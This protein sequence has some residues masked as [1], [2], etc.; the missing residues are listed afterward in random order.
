MVKCFIFMTKTTG[1]SGME[2]TMSKLYDWSEYLQSEFG[3]EVRFADFESEDWS[4]VLYYHEG[5]NPQGPMGM[6]FPG[7]SLTIIRYELWGKLRG[8]K[9]LVHEFGHHL[10]YLGKLGYKDNQFVKDFWKEVPKSWLLQ[11]APYKRQEE[12]VVD[13]LAR[14]AAKE[15]ENE[16]LYED[17]LGGYDNAFKDF[18]ISL[19]ASPPPF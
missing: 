17:L 2:L 19:G 8:F 13:C 1:T 3:L 12:M 4:K 6:Y 5:E 18:L 7:Q 9:T 11:Y 10:C 16:S 14:W 15:A